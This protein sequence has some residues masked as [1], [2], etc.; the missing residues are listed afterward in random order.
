MSSFKSSKKK[1]NSSSEI[2]KES[3]KITPVAEIKNMMKNATPENLNK[4][5]GIIDAALATNDQRILKYWLFYG[6]VFNHSQFIT[7][8]INN[9]KLNLYELLRLH[10]ATSKRSTLMYLLENE[11]YDSIEQLAKY[12]IIFTYSAHLSHKD[13]N[14]NNILHYVARLNDPEKFKKVISLVKIYNSQWNLKN[15]QNET[16]L[17]VA[18]ICKNYSFV[19]HMIH[20]FNISCNDYSKIIGSDYFLHNPNELN[21]NIYTKIINL[22]YISGSLP[23]IQYILMDFIHK[24]I[25]NQKLAHTKYEEWFSIP[26]KIKKN[27]TRVQNIINYCLV[28]RNYGLLESLQPV[29]KITSKKLLRLVNTMEIDPDSREM[30]NDYVFE[31]LNPVCKINI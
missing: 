28:N 18:L 13:N 25:N 27:D 21:A 6:A 16:P 26:L 12:K 11:M 22:P 9:T 23:E 29:L 20:T 30:F 7:K 31:Q 4:I 3:K 10:S 2:N 5:N 14:S 15:K 8:I 19:S 1:S 24:N 17:D